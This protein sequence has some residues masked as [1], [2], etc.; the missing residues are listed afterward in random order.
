MLRYAVNELTTDSA[1]DGAKKD[2]RWLLA[3]GGWTA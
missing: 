2:G 1:R 3:V